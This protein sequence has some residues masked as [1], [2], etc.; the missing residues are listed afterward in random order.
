MCPRGLHL[1]HLNQQLRYDSKR[2]YVCKIV[3]VFVIAALHL[4]L[5]YGWFIT[6]HLKHQG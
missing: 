2:T 1:C 3:R 5:S 4:K 6:S